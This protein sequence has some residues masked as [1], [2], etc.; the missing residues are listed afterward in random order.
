[1]WKLTLVC[2]SE[3]TVKLTLVHLL[4]LVRLGAWDGA[5]D[6]FASGHAGGGVVTLVA[7]PSTSVTGVAVAR[8]STLVAVACARTSIVIA[9]FQIGYYIWL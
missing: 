7:V 8:A 6:L 2:Q 3:Q 5:L 1:M 9:C 4:L